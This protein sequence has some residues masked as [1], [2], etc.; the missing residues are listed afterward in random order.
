M[1][2]PARLI[3]Q[4][5]WLQHWAGWL[6]GPLRMYYECSVQLIASFV[7]HHPHTVCPH[8]VTDQSWPYQHHHVPHVPSHYL[9]SPIHHHI[10]IYAS[11]ADK[12]KLDF[13]C[14]KVIK[15]FCTDVFCKHSLQFDTLTHTG[16]FCIH[17]TFFSLCTSHQH[18][19]TLDNLIYK[20]C[21]RSRA[22]FF[23]KVHLQ[24]NILAVDLSNP[25]E[26]H[27]YTT[28]SGTCFWKDWISQIREKDNDCQDVLSRSKVFKYTIKLPWHRLN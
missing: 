18:S 25:W 26:R 10:Q 7:P 11:R 15:I 20:D 1:T 16:N 19:R 3:A 22:S 28:V 2:L 17:F 21:C 13:P 27:R 14:S 5:T 9:I 4:W 24:I 23:Y 8:M 6:A 12:R